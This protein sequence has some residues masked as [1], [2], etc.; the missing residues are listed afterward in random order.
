MRLL[1]VEDEPTLGQQLKETLEANGYAVDLA[2]NG[3]DG[4]FQ[5]SEEDYDYPEPVSNQWIR[6]SRHS[7]GYKPHEI[8]Q[9][10]QDQRWLDEQLRARKTERQEAEAQKKVHRHTIPAWRSW[11]PHFFTAAPIIS[12]TW[13]QSSHNHRHDSFAPGLC[14][15]ANLGD[16][17]GCR[18]IGRRRSRRS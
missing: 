15:F 7:L 2:T 6:G 10:Q 14:S 1:I 8:A 16:D 5:G 12:G 3:V 11:A 13:L 4:H 9:M 18:C 17:C